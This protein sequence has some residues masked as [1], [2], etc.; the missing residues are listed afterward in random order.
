MYP[1]DDDMEIKHILEMFVSSSDEHR[2]FAH[3]KL[4]ERGIPLSGGLMYLMSFSLRGTDNDT[5]ST[6][7]SNLSLVLSE[8]QK[9]L[10]AQFTVYMFF[11]SGMEL[12][13][14]H[15]PEGQ[16]TSELTGENAVFIEQ[17]SRYLIGKYEQFGLQILISLETEDCDKLGFFSGALVQASNFSAFLTNPPKFAVVDFE[18][19][20]TSYTIQRLQAF[21]E[22]VL[23]IVQLIRAGLL[24]PRRSAEEICTL[25]LECTELSTN[26]LHR[27]MDMFAV[28]FME[29]LIEDNIVD[30]A[31]LH[32]SNLFNE[33]MLGNNESNYTWNL[34]RILT[35]ISRR[36][37]Y[38]SQAISS[39]RM[40][41]IKLYVDDNISN[42]N[43]SVTQIADHFSINRGTLSEEFSKYFGCYLS[44]YIQKQRITYA[45]QLLNLYPELSIQDVS[46]KAGYADISTMYRAFKRNG[47]PTPNAL[48]RTAQQNSTD[49]L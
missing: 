28:C 3:E 38:I 44:G 34:E 32:E 18:R 8:A 5:L 30:S 33:L 41:K 31:F 29:L 22:L 24:N 46:L 25:V 19:Q 45:Q 40:K 16:A 11:A 6:I 15:Q 37:D 23:K 4:E 48:R 47:L 27:H 14:L 2:A 35:L 17:M 7:E 36:H 39:D 49:V 43:L 21:R 12:M 10:S 42:V 1:L 26:T 20:N 13:L 9:L